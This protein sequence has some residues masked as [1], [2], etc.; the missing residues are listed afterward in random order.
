VHIVRD[1]ATRVSAFAEGRTIAEGSAEEVFDTPEVKRV[2]LR[3][4]RDT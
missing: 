3:G 1:V 2:F 4:R